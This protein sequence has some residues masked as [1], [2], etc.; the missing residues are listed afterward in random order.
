L[1]IKFG[2]FGHFGLQLERGEGVALLGRKIEGILRVRN[3]GE[4]L[5]I[6]LSISYSNLPPILPLFHFPKNSIPPPAL[7]KPQKGEMG[8][9]GEVN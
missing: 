3:G 6:S 2:Y 1:N 5:S 8:W 7:K 9:G 4:L